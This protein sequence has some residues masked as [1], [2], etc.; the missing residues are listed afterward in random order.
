MDSFKTFTKKKMPDKFDGFNRNDIT[1]ADLPKTPSGKEF[2]GV[3]TK[4]ITLQGET[5]EKG[6]DVSLW[7]HKNGFAQF[8]KY[9]NGSRDVNN[10]LNLNKE[11]AMEVYDY[12]KQD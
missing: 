5:F 3:L 10:I 9:K 1:I 7:Y 6:E 2:S 4:K 8:C 11:E 12:L